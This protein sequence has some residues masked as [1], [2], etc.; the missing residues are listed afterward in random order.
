MSTQTKVTQSDRF[1]MGWIVLIFISVMSTIWFIVLMLTIV[2]EAT[3]FMSAAAL[4][5]YATIVLCIPFRR[6][7]KWAWYATWI[8][9]IVFA[10]TIFF[11]TP[12][13]ATKYLITAV[14]MAFTLLLTQPAFFRKET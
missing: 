4:S 11:G 9:V 1:I 8:Q 2:G 10:S 14:V 6:G 12:E 13:I 3:L 7:E 5:L